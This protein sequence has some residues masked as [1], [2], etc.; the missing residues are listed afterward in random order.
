MVIKR[1]HNVERGIPR[2][3]LLRKELDIDFRS[4]HTDLL[5]FICTYIC[6]YMYIHMNTHVHTHRRNTGLRHHLLVTEGLVSP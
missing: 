6:T 5:T 4:L 2:Q 1:V 3:E